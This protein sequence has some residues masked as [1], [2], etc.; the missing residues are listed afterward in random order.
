MD[1]IKQ[2]R[3]PG[4]ARPYV[5]IV[6]TGLLVAAQ[7]MLAAVYLALE[8]PAGSDF[9]GLEDLAAAQE[10]ILELANRLTDELTSRTF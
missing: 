4:R 1:E 2:L 6:D 10:R 3:K 5:T 9:P 8:D 7:H